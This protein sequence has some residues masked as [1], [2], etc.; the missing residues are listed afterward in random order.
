[1]RP[2]ARGERGEGAELFGRGGRRETGGAV[3]P[4]G[5][6]F[7]EIYSL[8]FRCYSNFPDVTFNLGDG[9]AHA[10]CLGPGCID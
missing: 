9:P 5:G 10:G 4:N 3:T 8:H 7:G 1:M 2:E 6:F